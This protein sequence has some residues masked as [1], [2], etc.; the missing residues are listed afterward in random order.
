ME[1]DGYLAEQLKVRQDTIAKIEEVNTTLITELE[2][3]G[4][5]FD[6][7]SDRYAQK[8][9]DLHDKERIASE[10]EQLVISLEKQLDELND[11]N[12]TKQATIEGIRQHSE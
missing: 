12:A 7:L 11:Q 10:K 9:V 1:Q 4:K 2:E 3:L 8:A 6:E 5:R